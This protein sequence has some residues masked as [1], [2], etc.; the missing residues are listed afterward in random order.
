[1]AQLIVK[2]ESLNRFITGQDGDILDIE[3]FG[4]RNRIDI[5]SF[6][7]D[8]LI[9]SRSLIDSLKQKES[10]YS[11]ESIEFQLNDISKSGHHLIN[12]Y[13]YE[14]KEYDSVSYI[15]FLTKFIILPKA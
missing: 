3:H 14:V 9:M 1:M 2:H 4:N 8:E 7:K 13:T 10:L 5:Y 11:P 15:L 12:H 6:F